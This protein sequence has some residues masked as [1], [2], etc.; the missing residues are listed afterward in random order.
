MNNCVQ[1]KNPERIVKFIDTDFLNGC[2]DKDLT[3]FAKTDCPKDELDTIIDVSH[4]IHDDDIETLN[5]EYPT[6]KKYEY[7]IEKGCDFKT[8]LKEILSSE[9]HS[10]EE[11]TF[12]EAK[13]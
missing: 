5:E 2:F 6:Y 9:K 4:V 1:T 10:F 7:M 8:I 13:W 12:E 11:L 3:F